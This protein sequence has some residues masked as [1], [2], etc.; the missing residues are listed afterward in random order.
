MGVSQFSRLAGII[1]DNQLKGFDISGKLKNEAEL[2]WDLRKRNA[3]ERGRLAETRLT[4]P[5]A[6]LLLV[7]LLVTAAPA[8]IQVEGG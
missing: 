3:E 1:R 2:L 6:L 8:I 4:M 7:L 5:L